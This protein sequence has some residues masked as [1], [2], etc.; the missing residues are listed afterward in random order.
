MGLQDTLKE[1]EVQIE[2]INEENQNKQ[3]CLENI[4]SELRAELEKYFSLTAKLT[5]ECSSNASKLK[6]M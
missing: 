1:K 4:I 6:E 3:K 2:R 5:E